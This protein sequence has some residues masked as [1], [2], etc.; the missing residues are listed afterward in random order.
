[1]REGEGHCWSSPDKNFAKFLSGSD[2]PQ[3][4]PLVFALLN[5]SFD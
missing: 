4:D 5:S 3:T 2:C 1:M